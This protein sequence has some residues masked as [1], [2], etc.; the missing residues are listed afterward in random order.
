MSSDNRS[1]DYDKCMKIV[2][3]NTTEYLRFLYSEARLKE[4]NFVK[5]GHPNKKQL[6]GFIVAAAWDELCRR[7]NHATQEEFD[8]AYGEL[9][10]EANKWVG[11][12]LK[13]EKDKNEGC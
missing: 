9:L 4:M 6:Y 7:T 13:W 2:Q 12:T 5:S 11:K 1:F 8:K 3:G 10:S